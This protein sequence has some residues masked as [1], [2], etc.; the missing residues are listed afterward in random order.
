MTHDLLLNTNIYVHGS[1]WQLFDLNYTYWSNT[2]FIV[3][4]K[5]VF[6]LDTRN[7]SKYA[8][9][10]K[11]AVLLHQ[12][13]IL[14]YFW[15][16]NFSLIRELTCDLL[17]N[18]KIYFHWSKLHLFDLISHSRFNLKPLIVFT[19]YSSTPRSMSTDPIYNYFLQSVSP[20]LI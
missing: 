18:I 13:H 3:F 7:E 6:L 17:L 20:D 4:L 8:F 9:L 5:F 15:N 19:T 14:S 2:H 1:N 16:S 10:L 12:I 11:Y